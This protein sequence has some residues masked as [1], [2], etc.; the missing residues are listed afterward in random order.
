MLKELESEGCWLCGKRGALDRHHIYG[1][2]C[3]K[4]SERYGL[5]VKLCRS[6]HNEPPEGVH[7]NIANML[8]LRRQVQKIA[9]EHY[10]WSTEDFIRIFGRN[11]L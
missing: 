4:L 6:C 5:V 7:F 2:G 11:Y 9:M 1:G 10:G 8:F 3:R